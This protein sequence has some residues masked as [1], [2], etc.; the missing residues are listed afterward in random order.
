MQ[1][2]AE[3]LFQSCDK[4]GVSINTTCIDW[5]GYGNWVIDSDN[6]RINPNLGD[7]ATKQMVLEN[8]CE[9]WELIDIV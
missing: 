4:S 9:F 6:H 3:P 1:V 8:S 5:R 7:V 2:G